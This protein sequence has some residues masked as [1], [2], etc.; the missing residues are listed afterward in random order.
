MAGAPAPALGGMRIHA[1]D[2]GGNALS[3]PSSLTALLATAAAQGQATGSGVAATGAP[4]RLDGAMLAAGAAR[5]SSATQVGRWC[6]ET[7][8]EVDSEMGQGR[9]LALSF[10]HVP[11]RR[12]TLGLQ[13]SNHSAFSAIPIIPIIPPF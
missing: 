9:S 1:L 13:Y 3:P 11:L 2:D 6:G 7:D 4:G 10:A 5:L 8:R 12:M